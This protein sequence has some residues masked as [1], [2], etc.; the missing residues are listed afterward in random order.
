LELKVLDEY[1]EKNE[2]EIQKDQSRVW[3]EPALGF[4][5]NEKIKNYQFLAA[6]S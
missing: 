1:T 2:T 5:F 3:L 4:A 6:S